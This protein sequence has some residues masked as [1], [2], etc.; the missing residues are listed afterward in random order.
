MDLAFSEF[1]GISALGR[2]VIKEFLCSSLHLRMK[3]LTQ[4]TT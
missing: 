4:L 2:E 1:M 3:V